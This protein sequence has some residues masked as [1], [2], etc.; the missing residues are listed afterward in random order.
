MR[1]E[2]P[3][4]QRRQARLL[5]KP[6][7]LTYEDGKKTLDLAHSK[8]L[9]VGS[10][11]RHR[12]RPGHPDLPPPHRRRRDRQARR[13][14]RQHDGHGPGELAPEPR[15]LL[16]SRRRPALRHGPLLS[17]FARHHDGPAQERLRA[18]QGFLRRA[19]HHQPAVQ[20]HKG[21]GRNAPRTFAPRS[22]SPPAPSARSP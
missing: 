22:S 16:P 20:R 9:R 2:S 1:G 21:E 10:A 8:N 7:G 6:F 3:G 19:S 18:G 15:V 17:H 11:P 13:R 14:H 4:A 12:P 5:R